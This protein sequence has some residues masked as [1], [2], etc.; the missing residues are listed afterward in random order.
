M[1]G[2]SNFHAFEIEEDELYQD[3]AKSIFPDEKHKDEVL[4]DLLFNIARIPQE[5]ARVKNTNLH[6]AVHDGNPRVRL[7]YAFDGYKITLR[8]IEKYG[9][10]YQ[11]S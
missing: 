6:R 8:S 5:F 7:W 9:P 11:E 2:Q 4:R 3:Q 1:D 10:E